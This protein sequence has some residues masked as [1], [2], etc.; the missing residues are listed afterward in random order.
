M[1]YVKIQEDKWN[2]NVHNK[3]YIRDIFCCKKM[4][5]EFLYCS[6]VLQI[7]SMKVQIE[8]ILQKA[9]QH[10]MTLQASAWQS[11]KWVISL[12]CTAVCSVDITSVCL[13]TQ[14]IQ[15]SSVLASLLSLLL[16][17]SFSFTQQ[18][19]FTEISVFFYYQMH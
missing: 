15:Y 13:Y 6:Q 3:A 17:I 7:L 12:Y 1:I 2:K 19:L 18:C 14:T 11:F 9:S 10:I 5:E 16:P 4:K 8:L